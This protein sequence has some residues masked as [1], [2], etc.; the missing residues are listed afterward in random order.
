ML[1]P[2]PLVLVK[3][4]INF[5]FLKLILGKLRSELREGSGGGANVLSASDSISSPLVHNLGYGKFQVEIWPRSG[6]KTC[7]LYFYWCGLI[8]PTI[9]PLLALIDTLPNEGDNNK[10]ETTKSE[11]KRDTLSTNQY[12]T[13]VLK[14][15]GLSH[16]IV[17]QASEFIIDCSVLKELISVSN[18]RATLCGEKA[19]IPVRINPLEGR[20]QIF[21]AVYT[22][23]VEG[24]YNL[25]IFMNGNL[26]PESKK[27]VKNFSNYI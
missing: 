17:K 6:L 23:L 14:G 9:Y 13:V 19:D 26:L 22:P 7:R 21:K 8:V 25:N 3:K 11:N 16:A 5:Y 12:D 15:E 24:R 10:F 2:V 18:L 4:F 1:M 20:A 27:T